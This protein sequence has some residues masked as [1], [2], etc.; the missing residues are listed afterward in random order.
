MLI[1]QEAAAEEEMQME[2]ETMEEEVMMEEPELSVFELVIELPS[3]DAI[4]FSF[5]ATTNEI[6]NFERLE[7]FILNSGEPLAKLEII[8]DEMV[9]GTQAAQEG[10]NNVS[11]WTP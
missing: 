10:L 6:N 9:Q 5:Y 8:I 2:E 1:V 4:D 7:S 11:R 3:S